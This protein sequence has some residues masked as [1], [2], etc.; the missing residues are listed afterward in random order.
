MDRNDVGKSAVK[1]AGYVERFSLHVGHEQ[2]FGQRTSFGVLLDYVS[3]CDHPLDIP[4]RD[5][6]SAHALLGMGGD[7]VAIVRTCPAQGRDIELGH[8]SESRA[9]EALVIVASGKNAS[10]GSDI[11]TGLTEL[12]PRAF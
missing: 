1:G 3:G 12:S 5:S 10:R 2:R 8:V 9:R 7:E 6:A 4:V 11:V